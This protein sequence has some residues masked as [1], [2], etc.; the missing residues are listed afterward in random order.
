MIKLNTMASHLKDV[1]KLTLNK[2]LS[3]KKIIK[4]INR[5]NIED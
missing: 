3:G 1:K 4:N 2:L 5:N